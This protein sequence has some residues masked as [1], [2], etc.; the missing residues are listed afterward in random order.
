L[1]TLTRLLPLPFIEASHFS[2]SLVGTALLLLAPGL[3]RR[4]DGAALLTR[5]LLL[6]GALFSLGKGLD[7]EEAGILLLLAGLLEWT[8]PAFYRRTALLSE[9][10]SSRWIATIVA[11][12]ALCT[13]IGFIAY[14][15]VAYSSDLWWRFAARA[16]ASRFLRA[17]FGAAMLLLAHLVWRL[18]APS[19]RERPHESLPAAVAEAAL[20]GC[21][22]S[23]AMLA[24]TGDKC[25]IVG[26]AGNAFLMYRVKGRSWIVMGDPVGPRT[27]WPEL[28]WT[29]RA[30]ADAAQGRLL[31]Y[32]IGPDAMGIAIELGLQI[33]KYGEEARVDLA[34]FSVE[35][36][37]MRPLRHCV[38]RAERDGAVFE[39]VPAAHVPALIE[40][41]RAVS[42]AWLGHKGHGEKGFS[43]GHFD[44]AYLA[45]FDLA[46]VRA[47]GRI[48]AFANLWAAA[49]KAELSVD[50]MRQDAGA[51]YGTMDL[52]FARLMTW[53]RE[54]GYRRFSL[55]VAPLSGIEARRL[56]PG[57][58]KTA[59]FVFRHGGRFYGF[60]GV[61]AYK[62]KF[63]P[64]WTPR[65]VA[66]P[67]GLGFV[68]ALLDLQR[69]IGKP[70]TT[71]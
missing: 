37:G 46:V 57:W 15:Q 38:R 64:E 36:P 12:L 33:V 44:P 30:R 1:T 23:E 2:A 71:I 10:L 49:G 20:A 61:R 67:R 41:L 8:R 22:R 39:I 59:A 35:R 9:P 48:V 24:F 55:G 19:R 4:L 56:S 6:A 45:R 58:A 50:L 13:A 3:Y 43:L 66:G 34:G 52:L 26:A 5:A 17:S 29:I 69:L 47:G 70:R 68:R 11:S 62:E 18:L 27:A 63:R 25:F 28:L 51:P 32:Q 7:F 21:E 60:E 42:D 31:L 14:K 16:D 54:E 40:E 53:A 65:Y